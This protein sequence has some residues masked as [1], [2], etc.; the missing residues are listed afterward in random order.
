ME[1]WEVSQRT[2]AAL[3]RVIAPPLQ[4]IQTTQPLP[5]LPLKPRVRKRTPHEPR[6]D[7]RTALYDG[8]GTDLTASEGIDEVTALSVIRE[9]GTDMTRW[10][11]VTHFC[12]WLGLCPQH[13]SSGGKLIS[14]RT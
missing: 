14:S 8:T 4:R 13:K 1:G 6:F 2:I 9:I 10:Q 12:S 11:T 3:D 7:V 5:P